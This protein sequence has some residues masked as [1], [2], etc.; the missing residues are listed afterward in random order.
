[1]MTRKHQHHLPDNKPTARLSLFRGKTE[2]LCTWNVRNN[3]R[4][5]SGYLHLHLV[6]QISL[7]LYSILADMKLSFKVDDHLTAC[8][9]RSTRKFFFFFWVMSSHS[10]ASAINLVRRILFY[11][12]EW[13]P[14]KNYQNKPRL[15]LYKHV[16]KPL[17]EPTLQ[18]EESMFP[19]I[20]G[21]PIT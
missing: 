11:Q 5:Q 7:L 16:K 13:W 21:I 18:R 3:P 14:K 4:S 15:L 10:K 20:N 9:C 1:M 17:F 8:A 19:L 6:L 12:M 2:R